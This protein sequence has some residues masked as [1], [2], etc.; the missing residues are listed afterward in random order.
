M[1]RN[2]EMT[3]M[4]LR[5]KGSITATTINAEEIKVSGETSS[6]FRQIIINGLASTARLLTFMTNNVTRWIIATDATAESGANV[7]SDFAIYRYNDAGTF[8]GQAVYIQ[9]STGDVYLEKL[10]FV[11]GGGINF[12][13][14]QIPSANPN[15]L[16]DY[17]EGTWTPTLT[18]ATP[19]NLNVVYSVRLGHHIKIGKMVTAWCI[20]GTST[21]THTTAS[22]EMRITGLP[23]TSATAADRQFSGSAEID[24]FTLPGGRTQVNANMFNNSTIIRFIAS[25]SGTARVAMTAADHTSGVGATIKVSVTYEAV[26]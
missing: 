4:T 16:D 24:T 1:A 7:G 26:D 8:L 18:F 23:F 9:R 15:T 6:F 22:G 11:Q 25:G 21:F 3:F 10:L 2:I 5:A 19:G 12:P 17:E 14:T 20:I 13:T